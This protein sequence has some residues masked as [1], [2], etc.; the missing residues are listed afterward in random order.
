MSHAALTRRCFLVLAA[1]GLLAACSTPQPRA[2][3]AEIAAVSYR[4]PGASYITVLTVLNTG[5]G[6]GAHSALMINA[7]ERIIFD[8]AGSFKA[9]GVP[10]Y[11][12]VLFG[13]S[14]AVFDAYRGA[15]ARTDY[16]VVTQTFEVSPETAQIAYQLVRNYGPVP[17]SFCTQATTQVLQQVPGFEE[18]KTTLFPNNLYDQLSTMPGVQ[19]ARFYDEDGLTFRESIKVAG[20]ELQ[21]RRRQGE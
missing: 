13:V 20:E 18:V 19:T 21:E 4:D 6:S 5:S 9:V 15:N 8:P 1:P 17:R 3:A 11:D 16:H 7:N 10:E 14:P 2:S 12:D